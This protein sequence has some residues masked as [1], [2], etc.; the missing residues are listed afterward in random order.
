MPG[1]GGGRAPRPGLDAQDTADQ[2]E[3]VAI[4]AAR[5]RQARQRIQAIDRRR[6]IATM[7]D[8]LM[9]M[10]V[11]HRQPKGGFYCAVVEGWAA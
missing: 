9:P 3:S 1:N 8:E 4:V 2:S 6:R 10:A 11:W 7:A 5:Q